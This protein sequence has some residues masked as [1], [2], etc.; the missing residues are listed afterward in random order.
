MK[1]STFAGLYALAG[2]V[3]PGQA[4]SPTPV[5]KATVSDKA[6]LGFA[7]QN[8]GTTGGAGGTVTT[9][10]TL[11]QFTAAVAEKNTAPMIVVVQGNISGSAKVRVGSNK[12]IL[13]LPGAGFTG[14][15]LQVKKQ[16]N[17]IIRN[18]KSA[19]V[20]AANGDALTIDQSTNIWVDHCEF[21]SAKGNDKDFYDGLVDVT[22]ASD[23]VTISHTFFHDHWKTS[24]V[25]H[26]DSN[27]AQDLNH[28]R[29]TYANNHWGT[30]CHMTP[31]FSP[32]NPPSLPSPSPTPP[33]PPLPPKT[34]P[35]TTNPPAPPQLNIGS[36]APSIRFGTAHI[37]NNY[38]DH[39]TSAVNTR[40][41][42]RV[43][44]ESNAFRS[45]G[46]A[47]TS[48]DS[49]EA[50]TAVARDNDLGGAASKA[51]AGAFGIAAVIPY[52]YALLGSAAVPGRVPREAGAVLTFESVDGGNA[53][54]V[55]YL[56]RV[57]SGRARLW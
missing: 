50:G 6:D 19:S 27:A 43:V 33:G 48:A 35:N 4:E 44:V 26:S 54:A 51:P 42:A 10:S 55:P 7:T 15:G 46:D 30:T 57:R 16:K 39:V 53:T 45:V 2:L 28:L 34:L 31:S 11:A 18:I 14:I 52:R 23:F 13:G 5:R 29:V 56:R 22:H 17:V 20:V 25:G 37:Y 1:I 38:Y 32:P 24:L 8:G 36:R 40:M 12:S 21:H 49:S 47:I 3:A 9:V 41:G